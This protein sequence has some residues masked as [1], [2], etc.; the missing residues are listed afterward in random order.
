MRFPLNR[1]TRSLVRLDPSFIA[2]V[3]RSLLSS[4]FQNIK[5]QSVLRDDFYDSPKFRETKPLSFSRHKTDVSLL[6]LR[7]SNS[8]RGL[9]TVS[10]KD[11]VFLTLTYQWQFAKS[12]WDNSLPWMLNFRRPSK[13]D[14]PS[15]FRIR[16]PSAR[17]SRKWRRQAS[18]THKTVND[19]R[20]IQEHI[21]TYGE[22]NRA[23]CSWCPTVPGVASD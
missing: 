5:T 19:K 18:S 13:E 20:D 2:R 16:L 6:Q 1:R 4:I 17:I 14:R 23:R 12:V 3:V 15:K 21:Y 9:K 7:L 10:I 22:A 8:S 11:W